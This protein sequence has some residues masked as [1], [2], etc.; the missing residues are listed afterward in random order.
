M[1]TSL[2]IRIFSYTDHKKSRFSCIGPVATNVGEIAGCMAQRSG[3]TASLAVIRVS[4][5]I[6]TPNTGFCLK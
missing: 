2:L 3:A 6:R 5:K 4:P 1:K